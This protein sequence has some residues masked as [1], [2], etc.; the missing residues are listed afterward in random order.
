MKYAHIYAILIES[1]NE[2]IKITAV[3]LK[4]VVELANR[5]SWGKSSTNH[6]NA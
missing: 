2:N 3:S 6:A 5:V 4:S 1:Q